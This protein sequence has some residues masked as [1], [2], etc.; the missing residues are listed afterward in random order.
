MVPTGVVTLTSTVPTAPVGLTARIRPSLSATKL[1]H[2]NGPKLTAVAVPSPL[3]VMKTAVPPTDGPPAGPMVA[4]SKAGLAGVKVNRSAALV[5][6]V[7]ALV[8]T[9]TSTVDVNAGAAEEKP[10][11]RGGYTPRNR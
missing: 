7:P 11:A 3:P 6:V 2:L 4:T 8:V 1:E 5:A 10:I 9:V